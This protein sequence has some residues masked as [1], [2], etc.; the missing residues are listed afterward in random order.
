MSLHKHKAERFE[1]IA[2]YLAAF[3]VFMKGVD[4]IENPEK[5][6]IGILFIVIGIA[7]ALGTIFHHKATKLLRHFKAYV[8]VFEIIVMSIVGYMYM[9]EGKQYIQYACFATAL[10]F[11]VALI[12]YIRNRNSFAH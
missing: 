7:I 5:V 4:K 3:V 6:G 11:F 12:V 10:M 1:N 2:H 9:A 8:L